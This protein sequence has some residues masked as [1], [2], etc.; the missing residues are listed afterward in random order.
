MLKHCLFLI[1]LVG[2]SQTT[3]PGTRPIPEPSDERLA[4]TVSK[5]L[6]AGSYTYARIRTASKRERWVVTLGEVPGKGEE[7]EVIGFGTKRDFYSRRL[8][9]R[10]DSVVFGIVKSKQGER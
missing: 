10:F 9:R 6:S 2:C 7:V 3:V 5:R 8:A 4:G 1:L